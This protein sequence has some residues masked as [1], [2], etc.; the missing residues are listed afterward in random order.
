MSIS[1]PAVTPH[2]H[3]DGIERGARPETTERWRPGAPLVRRFMAVFF[4]AG[5]PALIYQVAW[6]RLL[7]LYFGV[8]VYSTSV[9]VASFMAGLGLG[10]LMGGR[11][12]DLTRRPA[13]WYA[14]IELL[15]AIAG[16]SSPLLFPAIG[17]EVAGSDLAV[18]AAVS[19]LLLVVPTTLMGMTLPMMSRIVVVEGELGARVSHLYGLNTLGAAVGALL[20]SY[21]L[22]GSLG[23]D[24]T[25]YVAALL[26]GLLAFT[27]W[28]LSPQ[29]HGRTRGPAPTP[30]PVRAIG[31]EGTHAVWM[32]ALLSFGSGLVALGYEIVWY[33]V[34]S[35]I[36]H[37]TVYVFGTVL[38]VYLLG[39]GFG[40]LRAART[41]DS[42]GRLLR[43]GRAQLMMAAWV[44]VFFVVLG[45][46]SALPGLRHVLGASFFTSFH[47]SPE[48]VS[49]TVSRFALYSLFDIPLW[50]VAMLGVPTFLMGY[51]FPNLVRAAASSVALL[52][53]SVGSVY[54]ANIVG[55][56]AGSLLVGFVT[57][58]YLGTERTLLLLALLGVA[59]GLTALRQGRSGSR[60]DQALAVAVGV[61]ALLFPARGELI[62]A[63]HFAD[64]PGVNYVARED[65][66]GVVALRTQDR[67]LAFAEERKVLGVSKLYIDGAAHG[68]G[69]GRAA[70]SHWPIEMAMA[71]VPPPRRVLS[72]G[73]GDGVMCV[74][75][76]ESRDLEE[77]VVVE[78]SGALADVLGTTARGAAVLR[79]PRVRYVVDDGRRWLLAHPAEKFDLIMMSPLH[80]AHAFSGNLFS[81]EFFQTIRS[82]LNDD[83]TMVVT[84]VDLFSTPRTVASVYEHVIRTDLNTYL[85][86]ATPFRFDGLRL[87]FDVAEMGRRIEADRATILEHTATAPL[88]RDLRPNSEYYLTYPFAWALHTSVP[89]ERMYFAKDRAAFAA[90]TVGSSPVR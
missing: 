13:A 69:D 84:T 27:V 88:N 52:G 67:V 33:R 66:S 29:G 74:A 20:T 65:R 21:L 49:G 89:S 46:L 83:G 82:H 77:L 86:R 70:T 12:A 55:A 73:L 71:S 22:I 23:L 57:L 41:I 15:L 18:V 42:P 81:K 38:C 51:G 64:F 90:L 75:A 31:R 7:S 48:L 6:Q 47:P 4:V 39:V 5:M 76:L 56:T 1:A 58:H 2:A 26:N 30:A 11:I 32:V 37:G 53:G 85:A 63:V 8:D 60:R 24:G 80:A 50:T 87:P 17:T 61:L 14:A 59:L 9:T 34:L 35:I 10:S 36:L 19:F 45:R 44:L 62:R 28:R 79:S 40:A 54:C 72:I 43:F 16:A 3:R 78:L 25:I 68:R